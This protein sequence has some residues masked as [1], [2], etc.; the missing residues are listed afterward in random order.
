MSVSANYQK[1]TFIVVASRSLFL[2]FLYSSVFYF[3]Q[4]TNFSTSVK[5][6]NIS[7]IFIL[8]FTFAAFPV[9]FFM[10]KKLHKNR[11]METHLMIALGQIGSKADSLRHIQLNS[12]YFICPSRGSSRQ[13]K[14]YIDNLYTHIKNNQN[15]KISQC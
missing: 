6:K 13:T 14:V 11:W 2:Y 8:F 12:K 5:C 9:C 10:C 4:Y 15:F 1:G 7:V 3:Y